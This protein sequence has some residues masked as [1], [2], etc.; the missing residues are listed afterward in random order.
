MA[1]QEEQRKE[2]E[3][4][5]ENERRAFHRRRDAIFKV[6]RQFSPVGN[7]VPAQAD[8]DELDAA[9]KDWKASQ[10]VV[11]RIVEEIRSGKR[12]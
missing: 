7:G 8:M 3:E 9:D 1:T 5:I 2:E 6:Q 11:E 12:R 4:A 10:V